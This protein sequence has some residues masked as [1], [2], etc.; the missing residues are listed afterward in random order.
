MRVASVERI[1]TY[2][3]HALKREEIFAI[4]LLLPSLIVVFGL[5]GYP[6]FYSAWISL[7]DMNFVMGTNSFVGLGNYTRVFAD[8]IFRDAFVRTGYFAFITVTGSILLGLGMAL[9]ANEQFVGRR[10]IRSTMLIPWAMGPIV[11]GV[12]WQ[13]IY[14]GQFGVL[15]GVLYQL[16]LI[17][18]YV[19]W[20]ARGGWSSLSLVGIAYL[21]QNAPLTGLLFLAGLQA[22]P[23]NLY[24]VA[25]V[26][27]AGIFRRFW[28]VTLPWLRPMLLVTMVLS[29]ISSITTFGLIYVLTKG[30]PG[31]STTV[32][33]WLGYA[34][35]V[36]DAKL[37]E[38]A[39]ILYILGILCLV[40]VAIYLRL[41]YGRSR[42]K[43][44][45][46]ST[47]QVRLPVVSRLDST[48]L[49]RESRAFRR[50][51]VARLLGGRIRR[52]M[53]RV[54]L[55][56]LVII[57]GLWTLLPFAWLVVGSFSTPAD[58]LSKPPKWLPLPPDLT[59]YKSIIFPKTQTG[60][61]V[62]TGTVGSSLP[63][64]VLPALWNSVK[65]SVG[66]S[67]L[68]TVL[69]MLA[70]YAYAR[71]SRF[72]F[73]KAT[74]VAMLMVRV[75]PSLTLLVPFFIIF[76]G[77]NL[78]DTNL[79]LILAFSSTLLPM[80]VWITQG[81][82]E[83]IPRSLERSAMVDGCSHLQAFLRVIVPVSMP[84]VAACGLYIFLA[85]WDEFTLPLVLTR[86]VRGQTLMI[87]T[88]AFAGQIDQYFYQINTL[89]ASAVVA[90]SVPVAL[91]IIFHK[92][93]VQGLLAGST[94]G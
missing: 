81:Y 3:R 92:Y 59:G 75:I 41:L 31:Y 32:F 4:S 79:A 29:T 62:A 22:I 88:A 30:G 39:A 7:H 78:L 89:L 46:I 74:A 42:P 68:C 66:T 25:Q 60:T 20:L 70:G 2:S 53:Q 65:V 58:L 72:G 69:G 23:R 9:I 90:V 80:A 17:H 63:A 67:L 64:K 36:E 44:R 38:G 91:G 40:L 55:Y 6:F 1:L 83:S 93:L 85:S 71:Y 33:S 13:W 84:V 77:L 21:W 35:F 43:P 57:V 94:K 11:V 15:N 47:P 51:A 14:S 8:R 18:D 24:A 10:L 5:V 28:S 54:G 27:G 26:D 50:P 76:R 61:Y 16:G 52:V 87:I 48:R 12:V 34:V 45:E 56:S 37:G 82:F 73:M 19:P 49:A 86:T